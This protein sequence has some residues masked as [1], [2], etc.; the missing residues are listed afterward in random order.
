MIDLLVCFNQGEGE[1]IGHKSERKMS[2]SGVGASGY[3]DFV[4]FRFHDGLKYTR[5]WGEI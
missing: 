3:M 1:E 5:A 4:R 2:E